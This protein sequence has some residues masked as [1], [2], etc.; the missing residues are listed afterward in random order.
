MTLIDND[1][2]FCT[3]KSSSQLPRKT[4]L[5]T[6]RKEWL[7]VHLEHLNILF[8]EFFFFRRNKNNKSPPGNLEF[9][10]CFEV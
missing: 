5:Q 3:Q 9:V 8:G 10:I 1:Q 6:S 2:F 4:L 7:F